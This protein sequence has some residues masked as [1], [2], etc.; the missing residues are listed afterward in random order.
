MRINK[1]QAVADRGQQDDGVT[2]CETLGYPFQTEA[3][4]QGLQQCACVTQGSLNAS[5][6]Q[7]QHIHN[8]KVSIAL[9]VFPLE[10]KKGSVGGDTLYKSDGS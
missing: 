5:R 10:R 8:N 4:L 9:K 2:M 3:A 1:G 7:E 6:C